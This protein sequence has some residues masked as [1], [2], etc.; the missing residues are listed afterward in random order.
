MCIYIFPLKSM[1]KHLKMFHPLSNLPV[2][3]SESW[4][5]KR[6]LAVRSLTISDGCSMTL[7]LK[8]ICSQAFVN[9]PI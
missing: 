7:D 3:I 2:C 8:A 6:A 9:P 4:A 5:S 1:Y